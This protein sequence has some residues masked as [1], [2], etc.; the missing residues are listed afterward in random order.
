MISNNTERSSRQK[1][2]LYMEVFFVPPPPL[3]KKK[4]PPNLMSVV[5]PESED[6]NRKLP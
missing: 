4:T 1:L 5:G 3:P 2:T 6:P